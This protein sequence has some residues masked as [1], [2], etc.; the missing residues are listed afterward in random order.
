MGTNIIPLVIHDTVNST[1]YNKEWVRISFHLSYID[2]VDEDF[3]VA[4]LKV[5]PH[6]K[7]NFSFAVP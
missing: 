7:A 4:T 2:F 3:L 5:L 6:S 1:W